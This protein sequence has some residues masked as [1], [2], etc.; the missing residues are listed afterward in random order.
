MADAS[1]DTTTWTPFFD[2][3]RQRAAKIV[4][5]TSRE[6]EA[7]RLTLEQVLRRELDL[8]WRSVD[9]RTYIGLPSGFSWPFAR[10]DYAIDAIR[11]SAIFGGRTLYEPYVRERQ[12]KPLTE[13]VDTVGH[14]LPAEF[15]ALPTNPAPDGHSD[16]T[17][18][19]DPLDQAQHSEDGHTLDLETSSSVEDME[20]VH[21]PDDHSDELESSAEDEFEATAEGTE[22]AVTASSE[23]KAPLQWPWLVTLDRTRPTSRRAQCRRD[24]EKYFQP[25]EI[26]HLEAPEIQK[27]LNGL[28]GPNHHY[29]LLTIK[30]ALMRRKD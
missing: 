7:E 1:D 25:D 12:R 29:E 13:P 8:S 14:E 9:G 24:L 21:V 18:A 17:T 26:L 5:D 2:Y 3:C 4:P 15:A 28:P 11:E 19:A 30:R 23:L 22:K 20:E 16:E 27:K 10:Y 6:Q